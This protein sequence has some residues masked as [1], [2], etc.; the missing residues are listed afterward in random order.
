MVRP[1]RVAFLGAGRRSVESAS[2]LARS[3]VGVPVGFWSRTRASADAAAARLDVP[4]YEGISEL[5][6]SEQPDLVAVM[7]HPV[8]RADL[9]SEAVSA[10]ASAL[11]V[12][13]PIA[14][15]PAELERVEAAA[16][17]V[18]VMVNTQYQWMPHWQRLLTAIAA[19]ELGSVRAIRSS[20]GVDILEQGPHALSLAMAVAR[21][22]D[23][24]APTWVLGASDGQIDF[25]GVAVPA[26]SVAVYD[27]GE[28]R[29]TLSAGSSA[30]A[31]PGETVRAFQ[32]QTEITGDAGVAWISLN[33]GGRVYSGS[34]VR[35]I[36]TSWSA[37]DWSSQT[38]LF[39]AISDALASREAQASFPT[40]LSE[41][42]TQAR[43]LF[44]AMEAAETGRRVSLAD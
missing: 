34:G 16:D 43:M 12:E 8:A 27:V 7:T 39:R 4:A 30:P 3:G 1:M 9:I 24:S 11:L 41:A 37:D 28:A 20:V 6:D 22:A 5:I 19:G 38:G 35:A 21:A 17:G 14:L 15:T 31:V 29:L 23:L 2:M 32:Q 25:G 18:F 44:G 42:A 13:K 10:G 26:D 36:D 40:R 33:Q